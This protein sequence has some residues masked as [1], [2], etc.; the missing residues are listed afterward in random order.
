MAISRRLPRTALGRFIALNQAKSKKDNTTNASDILRTTTIDRLD[1]IQPLYNS[2]YVQI[3]G[4]E[5]TLGTSTADKNIS[6]AQSSIVTRHFLL[7]IIHAVE[8]KETGFNLGDPA[9]YN[10]DIHNPTLPEMGSEAQIL[11]AGNLA[12]VG[13]DNR[14]AAGGPIAPFP[15]KAQVEAALNDFKTKNATQSTLKDALDAKK[16]AL[17]DLNE[18]ADAVFKKVADEVESFYNEEPIE[19]RRARAREWGVIY[20]SDEVLHI[21]AG[22]IT[23]EGSG[24]AIPG[25]TITLI[26]TDDSTS[27]NETGGYEMEVGINGAATLLVEA[28]GH[29]S[30]QVAVDIPQ[31]GTL[32]TDVQ[33]VPVGE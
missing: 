20:V 19:S 26:E 33:L 16:D 32:T 10:M 5:A 15:T 1:A 3:G 21:L 29:V 25:A 8:R 4:A 18:E 24:N 14:V 30:K 28:P 22:T 2:A 23:A 31:S 9:Y 27:S 17:A 6:K 7:S 13:E 11:A 12:I